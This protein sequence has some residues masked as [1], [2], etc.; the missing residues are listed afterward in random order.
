MRDPPTVC[1]VG[2]ANI[3]LTFRTPRLPAAGETVAARD[4]HFGCGGKGAN[5]AVMAARLGARVRLVATV[6][7]DAFGQQLVENLRASGVDTEHVGVDGTRPTGMAAVLVDDGARNCIA[8]A[9]GA[10][11]ALTPGDV[12]G[13]AAS[14]RAARVLLCQLETPPAATL[15]AFHIAR[16]AGVRTVL[17]PAPAQPLGDELFGLTDLCVANE[18]EVQLLTGADPGTPEGAAAAADALRRRGVRVAIVTLGARGCLLADGGKPEHFP[19]HPVRAVDPTGAGD[20][21]LGAL[22]AALAEGI[23]LRDAVGCANAAAALAVTRP[24]AQ[25]SFPSRAEVETLLASQVSEAPGTV[26]GERP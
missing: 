5:Q 10:N 9:P 13:A 26:M 1:V 6:G 19:A 14:L 4:F 23:G 24:G 20:A 22:A 12:R 8:V 21:F 11:G 15:E 3:D 18:S 25:G 2:S 16:A 17:N 7:A